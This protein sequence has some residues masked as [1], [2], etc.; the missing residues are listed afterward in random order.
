MPPVGIS[1]VLLHCHPF[2]S[3]TQEPQDVWLLEAETWHSDV[4]T[5]GVRERICHGKGCPLLY[6]LQ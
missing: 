3:Y 6:H 5:A 4:R 1:L 2:L